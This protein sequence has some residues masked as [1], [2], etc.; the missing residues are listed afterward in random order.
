MKLTD[1]VVVATGAGTVG[2]ANSL[3][4][5]GTVMKKMYLWA[6]VVTIALSTAAALADTAKL[7]V[8]STMGDLLDNPGAHAVLAKYLPDVVSSPQI[9]Q[10]RALTLRSLQQYVP[11]LT[12][13]MLKQI[14]EDLS[15]VPDVA[16]SAPSAA[17]TAAPATATATATATSAAT[18]KAKFSVES[19][20][21]DLLDKPE[22]HAILAKYLP[23][24]V[25]S[26]QIDQGR[27]MTLH[28]LQ[29]YLPNLTDDLLKQIGEELA[30][31]L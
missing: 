16:T 26:P 2:T 5:K 7:T 4:T 6:A 12:D 3:H 29:Q 27:P 21:G 22:A 15:H 9:D 18:D 13:D 19:T 10:G 23:D 14:G 25:S 1:D 11:N 28:S 20:M 31:I 30:K 24:V 17:A 8:E